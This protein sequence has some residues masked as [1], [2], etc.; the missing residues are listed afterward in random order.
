MKR[1]LKQGFLISLL[2]IAALACISF[3]LP[4]Q[5]LAQVNVGL[6]TAEQIGLSS[7]DPRVIAARIIQ[8][9][10]GFLGIAALGLLVYAGYLWMTAA[11]NE[12]QVAQAKNIMR[13]GA[14]GLVIILSAFSIVSFIIGRLTGATGI[15]GTDLG[16]RGAGG[17][18]GGGGG[19]PIGVIEMHYP[20]RGQTNVARN[21]NIMVTFVEPMLAESLVDAKGTPSDMT[22]DTINPRNI[23]ILRAADDNEDGPFVPARAT[24][25]ADGRSLLIDP[26]ELL[27]SSTENVMYR[28]ILGEGIAT[29][30]GKPAFGNFGAYSWE[31]EVG[32]FVD[33]E[34]PRVT[35]IVPLKDST[36]PRNV[37]IQ[38]T[39]SEAM[40]PMTV[41]GEVAKGFTHVS[42]RSQNN[43]VVGGRFDI[44][45][46]YRTVEFVTDD[47]CG[48]NSCGQEVYC[49]PGNATLTTTLRAATVST[50]PPAAAFPYDGIT[51]ASGNSFDGNADGVAQGPSEDSFSWAF[52]T[53]NEI[54]LRAPVISSVTPQ[55]YAT[56]V[57][58]DLPITAVFDKVLWFKTVNRQNVQV[59]ELETYQ[60]QSTTEGNQ[61]TV[62][63]LH[64]GLDQE[65]TYTPEISSNVRDIYQNCYQPCVG[66]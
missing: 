9:A 23:Q 64:T 11:G 18:L 39:F 28:V 63:I 51:D 35:S 60:I 4:E 20:D 22:D 30:T 41:A 8:G 5:A 56:S 53:T 12:E 43:E 47:L 52:Q 19:F 32:T 24:L 34:A 16:R 10:L 65:T 62:R 44:S 1:S 45:N 13:N 29:S 36:H 50:Q 58:L 48:Q 57:P 27:G 31:F 59:P 2:S 33:L 14:I 17:F 25:S 7:G 21:T 55:A 54:D 15:V 42:V 38:V 46:Q 61:S 40:N 3:A 6:E 49:L 26:V 66:P 37:I